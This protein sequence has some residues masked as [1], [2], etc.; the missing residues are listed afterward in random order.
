VQAQKS[1]ARALIDFLGLL[2]AKDSVAFVPHP[3][4]FVILGGLWVYPRTK[5]HHLAIADFI[6]PFRYA[7][8]IEKLGVKAQSP[9]L[10]TGPNSGCLTD[11]DARRTVVAFEAANDGWTGLTTSRPRM[12]VMAIHNGVERCFIA[13][14]RWKNKAASTLFVRRP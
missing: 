2:T 13:G 10:Y 12:S 8:R 14:P 1:R 5:G 4:C 7:P 6:T 11:G 3:G 9:N